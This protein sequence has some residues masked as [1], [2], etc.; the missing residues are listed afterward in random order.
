MVGGC[1]KAPF[2]AT[3]MGWSLCLQRRPGAM[4]DS[5][6]GSKRG[7]AFTC[8]H[9]TPLGATSPDVNSDPVDQAARR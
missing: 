4:S 7:E 6:L 2:R 8:T 9:F 5:Q 3:A 1:K